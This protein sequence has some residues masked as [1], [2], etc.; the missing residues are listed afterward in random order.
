MAEM[1]QTGVTALSDALAAAVERAATYTVSVNARRRIGATGIVLENGVVVT[2]DH[3][4]ER[5]EEIAVRL[6]GGNSVPARLAGRDAGTDIA[7]LRID[8]ATPAKAEG[9][10]PPR[11]GTLVLAVGRPSGDGPEV[12]LGVVS[13]VSGPVRTWRGG[14]LEGLIRTDA[15]FYPGFSGGPLIDI[16]GRVVGINTSALSR[17]SGVSLP[18]ASVERVA[19]TLLAHGKVRRGFLGISSQPVALTQSQGQALGGQKSGLL[20]VRTETDGP[21]ANA[22][23]LIGDILVGLAG[24]PVRDTEDLQR[25]LAGD[26]VGKATPVRVLRGGEPRE[27]SVTIGE[28]P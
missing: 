3:V 5:E 26:L 24:E 19:R 12:S 23:L 4:I 22:G 2:A 25:L 8:G 9:A 27:V 18:Y 7:V 10:P 15:T 17:S 1:E 16:A 11:V 20:I 13:A 14:Q 21:A 6:P 28:R